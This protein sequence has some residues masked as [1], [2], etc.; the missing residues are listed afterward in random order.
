MYVRRAIRSSGG[1]EE[2]GEPRRDG[3]G[4]CLQRRAERPDMTAERAVEPEQP[5]A[6]FFGRPQFDRPRADEVMK[7][8]R[9]RVRDLRAQHWTLHSSNV[10]IDV[11][12]T[13]QIEERWPPVPR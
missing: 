5:A 6:A 2:S 4:Q 9:H 12:R 7:Q 3:L 1:P 8:P 11:A 10:D 13:T